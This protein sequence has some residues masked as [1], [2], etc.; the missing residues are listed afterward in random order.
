[1]FRS[2]CA[3]NNYPMEFCR[4]RPPAAEHA[5]ASSKGAQS[6]QPRPKSFPQQ[7][8]FTLDFRD[9]VFWLGMTGCLEMDG[10]NHPA[11]QDSST[12]ICHRHTAVLRFL[13]IEI[14][15]SSIL[16]LAA[17]FKEEVRNKTAANFRVSDGLGK[18]TS[19]QVAPRALRYWL[20]FY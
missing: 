17:K 4:N 3:R 18:E 15:R 13:S 2:S 10:G 14:D 16:V 7:A 11:L 9:L 6:R 12:W 19:L 1:M 20:D 5:R 8:E